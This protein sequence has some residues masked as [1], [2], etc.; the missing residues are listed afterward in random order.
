MGFL[1]KILGRGIHSSSVEAL[2]TWHSPESVMLSV[3]K[4]VE[5]E[6]TELRQITDANPDVISRITSGS[7]PE[8]RC[9]YFKE[10]LELN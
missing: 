1:N 3:G 8:C 4:F 2:Y 7:S 9:R 10:F 6:F 5:E